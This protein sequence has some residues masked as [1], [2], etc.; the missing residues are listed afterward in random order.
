MALGNTLPIWGITEFHVGETELT[1][2]LVDLS[3]L[4]GN[5]PY[6]K[7]VNINNIY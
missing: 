2:Y 6:L 5:I 7:H 4:L 3:Q 1:T